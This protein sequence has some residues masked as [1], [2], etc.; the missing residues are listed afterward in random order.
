METP[1]TQ[2]HTDKEV[3]VSAE[4]SSSELERTSSQAGRQEMR[5][6]SAVKHQKARVARMRQ[7]MLAASVIQ[8]A[9][10][11]HKKRRR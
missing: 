6:M 11:R 3:C 2:R 9:W 4:S 8:T 5:Y 10:R 7:C 1:V